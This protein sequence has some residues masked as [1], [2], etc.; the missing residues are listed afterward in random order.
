[1]KPKTLEQ[2][3]KTTRLQMLLSPKDK[4]MLRTIVASP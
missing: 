1:M 3:F 2:D 4:S